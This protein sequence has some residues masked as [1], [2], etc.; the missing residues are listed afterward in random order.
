MELE[1]QVKQILPPRD[2]IRQMAKRRWDS[3]AKPLNSLGKLEDVVV[4]IAGILGR[5]DEVEV[6]KP[7][8]VIMCA[9][10]GVVEEGVTQTGKEVT[11]IVADN[12]TIG[13]TSVAVMAKSA[14]VD[15]FPIDIGMD[16]L[17]YDQKQLEASVLI[18]RK[19]RSGT[20]NLAKE[21]AMS[22]EE[23][24][25]AI[26]V[27]IDLVKQL[28]EQGYDVIATG[29]M[30]IGNT[31]PSSALTA[32][33]L[34]K[35]VEEVT[36]RGAGLSTQ[37]LCKKINAIHK[38]IA[39]LDQEKKANK[40]VIYLLSQIGG[41]DLA[42]M[43]GLYLGGAIYRIPIIMDGFISSVSALIA[44]YISPYVLDYVIASHSS[45]EPAG[46]LLME[47]LGLDPFLDCNMCLGEG[48]GAILSIPL[49]RMACD[50]YMQMST[51]EEIEVEAYQPL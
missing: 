16:C 19:I 26:Q 14:G 22:K 48:T 4:K 32:V 28:K 45:K 43:T 17:P 36:G 37:G 51:F 5:A 1:N 38:G 30:G 46:S 47:A 13:K 34:E 44:S 3:I 23:C 21:S 2:E 49:I 25:K 20:N 29:E 35:G 8:L 18:D 27:G 24:R 31:T 50:I 41:F 6:R 10:H 11:K 15:L 33:L 12:F 39:R 9:D 40:D 42:G 7:A